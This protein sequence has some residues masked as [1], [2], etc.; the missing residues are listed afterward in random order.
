M[1]DE[2]VVT[3]AGALDMQICVPASFSDAEAIGFAEKEY[4][5]G[6]TNG[7]QIRK[8]GSEMLVGMPER[9]PCSTRKDFVH[10]TLEA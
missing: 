1:S 2:P 6:T 7:W 8:Q 10:I 4:P 3:R 5:C 9:N